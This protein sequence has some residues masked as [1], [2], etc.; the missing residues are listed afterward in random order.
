MDANF[1]TTNEQFV[2]LKGYHASTLS[3]TSFIL[4]V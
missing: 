4:R 3:N 1:L 2:I